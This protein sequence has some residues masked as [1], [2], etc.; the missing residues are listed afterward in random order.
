MQTRPTSERQVEELQ[1]PA[2]QGKIASGKN[3]NDDGDI[4]DGGVTGA[5]P[6]L[7]SVWSGDRGAVSLTLSKLYRREWY[8][9]GRQSII[10]CSREV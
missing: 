1:S 7:L 10:R 9:R 6:L 3:G 5:L 8:A 2:Q 4:G